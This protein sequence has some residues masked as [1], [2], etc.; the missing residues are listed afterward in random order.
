MAKFDDEFAIV[1]EQANANG[2]T[3]TCVVLQ[4]ATTALSKGSEFVFGTGVAYP[5]WP[6]VTTID[7]N[8]AIV[9]YSD[10][11]DSKRMACSVL[12]RSV[13]TLS[14]INTVKISPG[15]AYPTAVTMFDTEQGLACY[16]D[17]NNGQNGT[18]TAILWTGSALEVGTAKTIFQDTSIGQ[19]FFVKPFQGDGK[20]G[21]VCY[22][23][24][25]NPVSTGTNAG[26]T[27][28]KSV[29]KCP[30]GYYC[31]E[32][33]GPVPCAAGDYS[34][35]GASSCG[36]SFTTI[37]VTGFTGTGNA[38]KYKYLGQAVVGTKI[39]FVPLFQDNVGVFDTSTNAFTTIATGLTGDYKYGGAVLVG[40]KIYCTPTHQNNVGV[41][42]TTNDSFATIDISGVVTGIHKYGAGVVVGTKIYFAPINQD[43]V[44]VFDTANNVFATIDISAVVDQDFKYRN[45]VIVGTKIYFVP[46]QG[47]GDLVLNCAKE[48]VFGTVV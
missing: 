32:S 19:R 21:I 12:L 16:A 7:A 44:G 42:D 8:R 29:M 34:V 20:K 4:R 45:A 17:H 9:C 18:C 1:C 15:P 10:N 48:P 38:L 25:S 40:T 14:L 33:G 36:G 6:Q 24:N 39:Y 37:A 2:G 35:A 30:A 41:I 43:N 28:C 5:G 22:S 26:T 46:N 27:T 23:D 31:P 3:G 13:Q 47:A 11:S